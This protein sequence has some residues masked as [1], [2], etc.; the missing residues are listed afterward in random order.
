MISALS[1]ASVGLS[2]SL[3]ALGFA[4]HDLW[5]GTAAVLAAGALWLLAQ[6]R[7]QRWASPAGLVAQAVAGAVAM[8]LGVGGGWPLLAIVAA[9]VAWDL[10]QFAQRMQEAGRVDDAPGQ[11]RL[12][13]RRL[14][15]VAGLGGLL[16]LAALS[17]QVRLSFGLALLMAVVMM[18][19]LSLVIGYMR[20]AGD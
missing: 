4:L 7:A 16:G 8:L 3:L 1:I 15:I 19:C 5:A 14:L 10:D 18:L 13:T 2:A 12:H 6:W 9:L 11:E 20:R 17:L